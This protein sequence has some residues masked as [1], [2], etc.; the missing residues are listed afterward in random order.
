MQLALDVLNA[1]LLKV[2]QVSSQ[3]Q[4]LYKVVVFNIVGITKTMWLNIQTIE[5]PLSYQNIMKTIRN[6]QNIRMMERSIPILR[7]YIKKSSE[8]TESNHLSIKANIV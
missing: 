6:V 4:F 7:N 5:M 8:N 2:P 3:I 1:F